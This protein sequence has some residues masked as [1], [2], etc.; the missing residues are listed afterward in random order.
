[1]LPQSYS[2]NKTIQ[3]DA[4]AHTVKA[5]ISDFKQWSKWS[6]WE[7]VTPS[8]KFSISE[9]SKGPGA[10]Q[11]WTSQ[12]GH[13]EMTITAV[14]EDKITFNILLNED[15]I[16]KGV[17]LITQAGESV[18]VVCHIEGQATS[19]L[20]SG[21]IAMFNEYILSNAVTLGLHNLKTV[22]QLSNAQKAINKSDG[23]NTGRSN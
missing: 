23:K 14:T 3:I 4:S 21:Y 19:T 13:G 22:A 5:L 6:P 1:M 8:I 20:F 7:Q 16:V 17:I 10:Y 15:N 11:S 9:P 18:N 2:A 12:W